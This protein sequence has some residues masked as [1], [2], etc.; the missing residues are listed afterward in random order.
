[1][2]RSPARSGTRG[3]EGVGGAMCGVPLG[4][5]HASESGLDSDASSHQRGGGGGVTARHILAVNL[6][7]GGHC[8]AAFTR[9]P[10][11]IAGRTVAPRWPRAAP[12]TGMT[13][14][15]MH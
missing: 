2:W 5:T 8:G 9:R 7:A 12:R 4:S 6:G 11:P 14:F 10:W 3:R 15:R 13:T 1:M